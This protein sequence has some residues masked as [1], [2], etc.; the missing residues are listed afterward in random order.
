MASTLDEAT[1]MAQL[2]SPNPLVIE[3]GWTDKE[4]RHLGTWRKRWLVLFSDAC[5]KLPCLCTFKEPRNAWERSNATPRPTERV[6]LIGASC[7]MV[8]PRGPG[9]DHVFWVRAREGDYFFSTESDEISRKW[10]RV[11]SSS[12]AEAILIIG[13]AREQAIALRHGGTTSTRATSSS[14]HPSPTKLSD[15][16][17]SAFLSSRQL[18]EAQ[19][20]AEAEQQR[21][22]AL[23]RLY[24]E[25]LIEKEVATEAVSEAVSRAEAAIGA[26][27]ELAR[28]RKAA[29]AAAEK[30]MLARERAEVAL[31]VAEAERER[32]SAGGWREG[33]RFELALLHMLITSTTTWYLVLGTHTAPHAYTCACANTRSHLDTHR[34]PTP[35]PRHHLDARRWRTRRLWPRER[36]REALEPRRSRVSRMRL[37]ARRSSSKRRLSAGKVWRG[38]REHSIPRSHNCRR[39]LLYSVCGEE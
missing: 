18:S 34:A 12:I 22:E 17:A 27:A 28:E 6:M 38:C 23:S 29:E 19:A 11:I 33:F 4:S 24:S 30:M 25:A 20:A 2:Q 1:I 36:R 10:V 3:E 15:Q 9:R 21:A 8:A 5:N 32:V 13:G 26:A 7:M 16:I 31:R 14:S 37:S 39:P 35:P